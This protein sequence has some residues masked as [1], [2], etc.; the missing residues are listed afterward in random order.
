MS[1][2]VTRIAVHCEKLTKTYGS[3]EAEVKALR[4]VDLDIHAG[5]LLLI[6]EPS[7]CGKTTLVS[8]IA[9]ILEKTD[10]VCEVLGKNIQDMNARERADFRRKLVASLKYQKKKK[11]SNCHEEYN[12]GYPCRFGSGVG[13]WCGHVW[14]PRNNAAA[15][16]SQSN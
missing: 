6:T 11:R 1:N 14:Q 2:S 16:C 7:G 3:G 15:I 13:D 12:A 4:G 8:V 5:E 10:G 9:A